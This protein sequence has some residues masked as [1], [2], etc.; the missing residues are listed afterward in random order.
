MKYT[1][2]NIEDAIFTSPF[3]CNLELCKG[4]CCTIK[5]TLGAPSD[6]G[7]VRIIE[8]ILPV[9]EPYLEPLKLDEIIQ[10][11]F[12][13]N[14]GDRVYLNTLHGNDCVFSFI[15]NGIAKCAIE[16]AYIEGKIDFKKPVSCELFPIRYNKKNNSLRYE[17][18]TE[19][20]GAIEYGNVMN[21]SVAEFV[22][23]ALDRIF[24]EDFYKEMINER[25]KNADYS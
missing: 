14:Y 16:K 1:W 10:K 17:K 8:N 7:E 25:K 6:F 24:G 22:R 4:A 12:Y 3:C 21:I 19:C 18:I 13:E 15:D 9:V 11:G 23:N 20:A 2:T 5:G